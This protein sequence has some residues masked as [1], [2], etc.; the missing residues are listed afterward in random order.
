MSKVKVRFHE[1]RRK[2]MAKLLADTPKE[3]L[4]RIAK[5]VSKEIKEAEQKV[6]DSL[7]I[8]NKDGY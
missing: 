1:E 4:E 3:E 2:M 8:F 7:P 6:K 5:K